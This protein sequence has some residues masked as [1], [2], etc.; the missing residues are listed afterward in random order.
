MAPALYVNLLWMSIALLQFLLDAFI[1]V[2]QPGPGFLRGLLF[3]IG[4]GL[5]FYLAS[6]GGVFLGYYL[7]ERLMKWWYRD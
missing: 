7:R 4:M 2:N 6:A 1:D 3:P 5:Y